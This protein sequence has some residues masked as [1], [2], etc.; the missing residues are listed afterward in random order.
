MDLY[1][2]LSPLFPSF[3]SF[4]IF[5]LLALKF[6]DWPVTWCTHMVTLQRNTGTEFQ[7][8]GISERPAQWQCQQ[9]PPTDGRYQQ[10]LAPLQADV[11]GRCSHSNAWSSWRSYLWKVFAAI[12]HVKYCK[13][14]LCAYCLIWASVL[15]NIDWLWLVCD[16]EVICKQ[17]WS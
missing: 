9:L 13:S 15:L 8:V 12:A 11:T 6:H 2:Q 3:F 4:H 17:K 5:S 16:I 7:C 14:R 10:A 1:K